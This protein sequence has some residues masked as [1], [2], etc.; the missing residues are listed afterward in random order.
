M[1]A[2]SRLKKS[3]GPSYLAD[4]LSRQVTQKYLGICLLDQHSQLLPPQ[5]RLVSTIRFQSSILDHSLYNYPI[6][7]FT[8]GNAKGGP[9]GSKSML[10][11]YGE[12]SNNNC[13]K[14]DQI[15]SL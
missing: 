13:S 11:V 6:S 4:E 8:L 7:G 5:Q 14:F 2:M 10:W 15:L 9:A 12:L 1:L 3:P